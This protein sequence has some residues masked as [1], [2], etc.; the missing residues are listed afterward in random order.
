M[1]DWFNLVANSLWILGC[2]LALATFSYASWQASLYN[3][4][5]RQRL[6]QPGIQRSLDA[7]GILFCA[8]LAATSKNTL[9]IGLWVV[10]GVL[11]AVQLA[12]TFR[13]RAT[14][15]SKQDG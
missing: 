3:E 15:A 5:L 1:I 4:K 7:S 8:G 9:E 2:A 13:R 11:F 10:L 14:P 12:F 6:G